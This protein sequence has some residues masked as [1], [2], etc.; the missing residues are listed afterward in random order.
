[1]KT[2]LA[3]PKCKTW[4][5]RIYR[6]EFEIQ[7]FG[8]ASKSFTFWPLL[9]P[10]PGV[11][12]LEDPK[13]HDLRGS[14]I[15]KNRNKMHSK[16]NVLESS[17]NHLPRPQ[18]MKNCPPQSQ[19][20]VPRRLGTAV[21]PYIL[22]SQCCI[23]CNT[24]RPRVFQSLSWLH[25]SV[26]AVFSVLDALPNLTYVDKLIMHFKPITYLQYEVVSSSFL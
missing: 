12:N 22:K 23:T 16:C 19:S 6:L 8:R 17:W 14:W 10:T 1:M 2:E 11:P 20:L 26:H 13:P 4:T 3:H 25:V 7:D 18:A 5:H 24:D 9:Y 21:L 15:N